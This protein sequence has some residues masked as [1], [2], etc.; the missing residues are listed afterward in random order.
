MTFLYSAMADLNVDEQETE[1]TIFLH[2]CC[3]SVETADS[4]SAPAFSPLT[5][6]E[7]DFNK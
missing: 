5:P 4:P 7:T 3:N 6:C 1:E 2:A